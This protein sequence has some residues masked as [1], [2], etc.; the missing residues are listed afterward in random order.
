MSEALALEQAPKEQK[1]SRLSQEQYSIYLEKDLGFKDPSVLLNGNY[2][3]IDEK[4][5]NNVKV[6]CIRCIHKTAILSADLDSASNLLRHLRVS[7]IYSSILY[8][9]TK[10]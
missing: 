10:H 3:Q 6:M 9:V 5:G 1:Y 8:L 7:T 4:T 2:F